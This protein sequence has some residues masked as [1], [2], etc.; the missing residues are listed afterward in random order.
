MQR[1]RPLAAALAA[2][3]TAAL[4]GML[5]LPRMARQRERVPDAPPIAWIVAP[6]EPAVPALRAEAGPPRVPQRHAAPAPQRPPAVE[7]P[8]L[9]APSAAALE[10]AAHAA[11]N[12][13]EAASAPLRLDPGTLRDAIRASRSDVLQMADRAGRDLAPDA[14]SNGERTAGAIA[15]AK[16]PD[17]IGPGGSLLSLIIIPTQIARGKCKF[18]GSR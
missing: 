8:V 1:P 15:A 12:A 14:Q 2:A 13:A 18:S 11:P 3:M 4:L 17:C 9:Q 6:P 10:P 16:Q 7:A 5:A